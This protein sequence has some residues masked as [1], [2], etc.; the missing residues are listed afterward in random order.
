[1]EKEL[2]AKA[3]SEQL[4][5]NFEKYKHHLDF[6]YR[7]FYELEPLVFQ[8]T[9]CLILNMHYAAITSTNFF[10]ERLL[11]VALINK[12]VGIRGIPVEEWT[13]VYEVPSKRYGSLVLSKSIEQCEIEGLIDAKEKHLL[14]KEVRD[15]IRNG[16]SHAEAEK[17]LKKLPD[18]VEMYSG[19]FNEI[20]KIQPVMLN[21]KVIPPLQT[22]H[23]ETFAEVNAP[24][25]FDFVMYLMGVIENRLVE[26]DKNTP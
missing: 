1:M 19:S 22:V 15:Q 14:D 7:V 17:I 8:V 10:L 16:F 24:E 9:K 20:G 6:K 4:D 23:M 11:K 26:F 3:F 25:Y 13:T 2:F 5:K 21:A 18:E 12:A